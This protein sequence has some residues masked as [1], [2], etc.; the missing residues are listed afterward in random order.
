MSA[1]GIAH[2]TTR[3]QR[4]VAKLNLA[5]NNRLA[6]YAHRD[7]VTNAD[8]R[9]TYDITELPTKYVGNTVTTQS[10]VGGLVQGRPWK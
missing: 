2:L 7:T 1:N 5:A 8:D 3:E 10:H 9:Y 4:Q 6:D